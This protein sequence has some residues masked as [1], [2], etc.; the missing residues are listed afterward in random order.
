MNLQPALLAI[1]GLLLSAMVQ[2]SAPAWLDDPPER[3]TGEPLRVAWAGEGQ[4]PA[5]LAW[6][7]AVAP[8]EALTAVVP[9]ALSV[10]LPRAGLGRLPRE[11]VAVPADPALRPLRIE[12]EPQATVVELRFAPIGGDAVCLWG[13]TPRDPC[14]ASMGGRLSVGA[15]LIGEFSTYTSF[16]GLDY[17]CLE[18]AADDAPQRSMY[19]TPPYRGVLRSVSAG[20]LAPAAMILQAMCA[21][22]HGGACVHTLSTGPGSWGRSH[23]L[24]FE[25]AEDFDASGWCPI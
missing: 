5:W 7:D 14:P 12:V 3:V 15:R 17:W 1:S 25:L 16:H 9:D 11:L 6:G 21:A 22:H 23:A 24:V 18:R 4:R 13:V 19:F 20:G 10:E 2:A 8:D